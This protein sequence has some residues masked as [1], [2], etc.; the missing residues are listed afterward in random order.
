MG[1]EGGEEHLVGG[2]LVGLG[3]EADGGGGAEEG[4]GSEREFHKVVWFEMFQ[5]CFKL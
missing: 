2:L 1:G 3:G 4:G 5:F